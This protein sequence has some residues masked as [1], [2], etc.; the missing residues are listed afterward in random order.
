MRKLDAPSF[1]KIR[2]ACRRCIFFHAAGG[3]VLIAFSALLAPGSANA[4]DTS[5][6]LVA[7]RS[8]TL[9]AE[10]AG[11]VKYLGF[12]EGEVFERGDLLVSIDCTLHQAR[13]ARVEAIRD[14]GLRQLET[15]E[16]LNQSGATSGLELANAQFDLQ[17]ANAELHLSEA[18]VDRC[19]VAAPFDGA[20]T[21]V[22]IQE[23]EYV[24]EGQPLI[25]ILDQ[26]TIEA[27]TFVPS[28]LLAWLQEGD[29]FQIRL[30][31]IDQP[32]TARVERIAPAIDPVSQS[33]TIYGRIEVDDETLTL[34]PGMSG[35]ANF[36]VPVR[37]P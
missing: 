26:S 12:R 2:L 10:V 32:L 25:D 23:H 29:V 24:N 4:E 28:H 37:T 3:V 36:V 9:S 6:R 16:M 31:E 5:V 14:R 20:V 11:R 35:V 18:L 27:L 8:A 15:L 22:R 34:R 1:R 21:V 17:A 13:L 30:S 19:A 33:V 7:S